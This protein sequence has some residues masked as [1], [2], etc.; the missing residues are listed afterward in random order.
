MKDTKIENKCIAK[1]WVL[2][3]LG[4]NL[5]TVCDFLI[6]WDLPWILNET[7]KHKHDLD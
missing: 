2:K 5:K 1:N 6:K 7:N 4:F 3:L